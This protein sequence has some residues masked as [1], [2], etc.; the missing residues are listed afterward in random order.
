MFIWR[1]YKYCYTDCVLK[2]SRVNTHSKPLTNSQVLWD[3][4]TW[5]RIMKQSKYSLRSQI[6]IIRIEKQNKRQRNKFQADLHS[7]LIQISYFVS[8]NQCDHVIN[9]WLITT[10]ESRLFIQWIDKVFYLLA[11]LSIFDTRKQNSANPQL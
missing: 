7:I 5:L 3:V 9:Q 11:P 6:N 4:Y 2:R 10:V 1:A 8:I